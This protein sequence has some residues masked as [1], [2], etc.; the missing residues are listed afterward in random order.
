MIVPSKLFNLSNLRKIAEDFFQIIED[1]TNTSLLSS[2]PLCNTNS[3]H[4]LIC[5]IISYSGGWMI[6]RSSLPCKVPVQRTAVYVLLCVYVHVTVCGR[7]LTMTRLL[8]PRGV[9]VP[10]WQETVDGF[11]LWIT[12]AIILFVAI[13]KISDLKIDTPSMYEKKPTDKL[14]SIMF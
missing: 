9:S 10:E 4:F 8:L 11:V 14:C 2:F 1:M 5:L 12:G 6:Q 13:V 3:K 7:S